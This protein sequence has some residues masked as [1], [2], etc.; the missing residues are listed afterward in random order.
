MAVALLCRVERNEA[1]LWLPLLKEAMPHERLLGPNPADGAEGAAE[2]D[3]VVVAGAPPGLLCAFPN[4]AFIQSA[5]AGVDALLADPTLPDGVPVARLIDPELGRNMSEA[6][7]THVLA[8]HR[9]APLY[10]Q[11]QAASMWRP[12][13]QPMAH[14]RRVGVLGLGEMGLRSA[15]RLLEA[16]FQVSGWTRT[17]AEHPGI[18][19]FAGPE[20]FQSFLG[21]CEMIVNLLPLTSETRGLLNAR[22]FAAMPHGASLINLGR[23]AHIV[24]PDLVE[25]LD[26]GR[27]AH[28]VLDVFEQEPLPPESSL[29]A[30]PAVTITPHVAAITNPRTSA[31]LIAANI[32]RFRAGQPLEG[33]V[34]RGIG[35]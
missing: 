12:W 4:L 26:S 13:P 33:L 17:R 6:V 11:Q 15:R 35:Y 29:W 1:D 23:G 22:A 9:R 25:A 21:R 34:E 5:W 32:A 16:G 3:V 31:K 28:A 7:L 18:E 27:L 8:L 30:H 10:R 24:V 19:T 20:E 14:E 2:V